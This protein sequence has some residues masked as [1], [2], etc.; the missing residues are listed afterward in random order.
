MNDL[1]WI[2]FSCSSVSR[3]V[4]FSSRQYDAKSNIPT[5]GFLLNK[6]LLSIVLE[7]DDLLVMCNTTKSVIYFSLL[8]MDLHFTHSK[9]SWISWFSPNSSR[10]LMLLVV[11]CYIKFTY[12]KFKAHRAIFF[13]LNPKYQ[14][15]T[16][17]GTVIKRTRSPLPFLSSRFPEY[18]QPLTLVLWP[19]PALPL[20]KVE[21]KVQVR[22]ILYGCVWSY[23]AQRKMQK[24][25][26][27]IWAFGDFFYPLPCKKTWSL[28]KL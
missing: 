12:C 24:V 16:C 19:G 22:V 20:S 11:L 6:E 21:L 14:G 13:F 25:S 7:A 23:K 17:Q 1:Q 28:N 10:F 2:L 26:N 8:I 5:Q 27:K 18:Q 3:S 4:R 9:P 15:Q